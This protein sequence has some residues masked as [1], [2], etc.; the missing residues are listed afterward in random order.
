[1]KYRIKTWCPDCQTVGDYQGCYGGGEDISEEIF[2]SIE[3]AVTQIKEYASSMDEHVVID[4][5]GNEVAD[6]YGNLLTP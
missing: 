1:M 6:E 4:E 5:E 3:A 2:D